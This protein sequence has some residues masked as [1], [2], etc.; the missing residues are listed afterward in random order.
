[1]SDLFEIEESKSP[2]LVAWMK[3]HEIITAQWSQER[4]SAWR[5]VTY[6]ASSDDVGYGTTEIESI[7]QLAMKLGVRVFDE[8]GE[9]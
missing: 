2:R 3:V 9:V 1:M 6:P 8:E 5:Q 7:R 4:W